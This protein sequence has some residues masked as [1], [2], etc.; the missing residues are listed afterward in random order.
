MNN[1]NEIS[2]IKIIL[3]TI[4]SLEVDAISPISGTKISAFF[5]KFI[6]MY[7]QL[8]TVTVELNVL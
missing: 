4:L 7:Y 1:S 8:L 2:A 5:H 3:A 6:A